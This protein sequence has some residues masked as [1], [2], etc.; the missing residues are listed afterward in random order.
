MIFFF[1]NQSLSLPFLVGVYQR[2]HSWN[3]TQAPSPDYEVWPV[4]SSLSPFV[5]CISVP[6]R[7]SWHPET[8][9]PEPGALSAGLPSHTLPTPSG[10]SQ[11]ASPWRWRVFP[12]PSSH[13]HPP[14]RVVFIHGLGLSSSALGTQWIPLSGCKNFHTHLF[15]CLLPR[16]SPPDM[17]CSTLVQ[18]FV[19]GHSSWWGRV[20]YPGPGRLSSIL[21]L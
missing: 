21:G 5:S 15:S 14:H 18:H 2:L 10:P 20:G 16:P 12:S 3:R 6:P 1:L 11:R 13:S 9:L 7:C 4:P 17:V 8:I 19:L